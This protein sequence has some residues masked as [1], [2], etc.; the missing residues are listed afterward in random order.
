MCDLLRQG[1]NRTLEDYKALVGIGYNMNMEGS[2]R[3]ETMED[4]IDGRRKSLTR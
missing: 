3:A 1:K 2:R 4:L